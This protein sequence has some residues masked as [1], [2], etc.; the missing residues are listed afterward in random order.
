MARTFSPGLRQLLVAGVLFVAG[1]PAVSYNH[2]SL[3]TLTLQRR[4]RRS[5]GSTIARR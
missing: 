5:A 3:D 2:P 4:C 1:W